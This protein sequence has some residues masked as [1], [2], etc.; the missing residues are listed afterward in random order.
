MNAYYWFSHNVVRTVYDAFFRG[1]VAGIENLPARGP[2]LVAGNHSSHLDPPFLGA[3]I[4][5]HISFFA[6]KT[7]WKPGLPARWLDAIEAIPVD[8]DG[9]SDVTAM[10]R[11][12][13]AFTLGRVVIVFPEG[14][15]SPDGAMHVPKPGLGMLACRSQ[16]PVVPARLFGAFEAF[17][18]HGRVRPGTPVSI[19][20]SR[21][22]Q[23][24][25]YDNP[26]D[27]KARYQRASER[28]MAAIAAI[29]PPRPPVV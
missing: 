13:A 14:T 18:R 25:D 26:A 3:P 8:R 1:D 5:E 4:S 27:G 6:R 23:A 16:V 21:P 19:V 10:R 2:Y 12:F 7:L 9:G 20:Y 11:V 29:E 17:D 15:R 24:C 22:L 28:I